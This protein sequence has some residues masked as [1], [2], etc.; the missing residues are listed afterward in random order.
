MHEKRK[1][2]M[3]IPLPHYNSVVIR[4]KFGFGEVVSQF[5]SSLKKT[6][7]FRTVCSWGKKHPSRRTGDTQQFRKSPKTLGKILMSGLNSKSGMNLFSVSPVL[8]GE[9][10]LTR[11]FL[12]GD[13]TVRLP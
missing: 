9:W 12:N 6:P 2:G 1:M 8:R 7:R 13:T 4:V 3:T 5:G 10:F 11:F